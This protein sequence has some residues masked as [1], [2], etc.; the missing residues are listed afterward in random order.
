MPLTVHR[1]WPSE[2]NRARARDAIAPATGRE[3]HPRP[4]SAHRASRD[5]CALSS[6]ARSVDT[7]RRSR[8]S[9]SA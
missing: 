7:G 3:S 9:T 8:A 5:E 1:P 4:L 2:E 6:Q